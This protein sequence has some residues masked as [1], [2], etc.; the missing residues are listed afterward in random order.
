VPGLSSTLPPRPAI[1]V[2]HGRN[3]D[4]LPFRAGERAKE[5]LERHAFQVT[6]RPFDGG[7]TIPNQIVLELSR[8]LFQLA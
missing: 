8:F 5:M 4:M 3:D 7:H 1:F 6:W 2:A